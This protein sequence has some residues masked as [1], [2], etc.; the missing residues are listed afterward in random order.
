[1]L[2]LH[3]ELLSPADDLLRA[4]QIG[5]PQR[6]AILCLSPR[7]I[8]GLLQQ[9]RPGVTMTPK[10]ETCWWQQA[11]IPEDTKSPQLFAA[12][13]ACQLHINEAR[14]SSSVLQHLLAASNNPSTSLL[15]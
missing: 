11:S 2:Q 12:L 3:A 10:N 15:K 9:Q 5:L 8:D 4:Q 6:Q 14:G 1:M 13:A 7:A